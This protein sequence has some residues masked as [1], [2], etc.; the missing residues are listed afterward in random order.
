VRNLSRLALLMALTPVASPA[1]ADGYPAVPLLSGSKTV[2]DEKI[3]YPTS[4][5]AQV[6]AMIVT[7][8]PGQKTQLH[9]HGVPLFAYVLEGEITVA[10]EGHG[11]RSYKQGESFLE[12]M[13]I[14]HAGMNS[15]SVPVKLLA[16]YMGAEGSQD[17]IKAP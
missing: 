15:G 10:Y 4:G 17:V 2:M 8:A 1:L 9:T 12:A 13:N 3:V 5:P 16:V 11:E 6:T 7:L 14:V